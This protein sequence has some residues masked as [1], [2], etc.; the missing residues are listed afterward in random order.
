M[1]CELN[2]LSIHFPVTKFFMKFQNTKLGWGNEDIGENG[3]VNQKCPYYLICSLT[4]FP[5][6]HTVECSR[7]SI[8]VYWMTMQILLQSLKKQNCKIILRFY[9]I[10]KIYDKMYDCHLMGYFEVVFK[11][12][13][14]LY[15]LRNYTFQVHTHLI[16]SSKCTYASDFL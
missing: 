7:H 12:W 10:T 9:A 1:P 13:W 3:T 11:I 16:S 15:I 8:S 2:F 4:V 14:I 5:E 6:S